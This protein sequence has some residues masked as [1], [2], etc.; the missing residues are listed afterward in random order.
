M[1]IT[2]IIFESYLELKIDDD[3]DMMMILCVKTFDP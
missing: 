1:K 3:D 2:I